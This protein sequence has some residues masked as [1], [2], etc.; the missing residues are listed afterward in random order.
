MLY[1]K[2]IDI[3]I[4]CENISFYYEYCCN[5]SL[6]LMTKAKACTGASQE[7]SAGITSHVPESVRE[8]EGM[9]SHTLK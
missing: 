5:P 4:K 6:G 1:I 2:G 8:C 9:N 3:C 7:G